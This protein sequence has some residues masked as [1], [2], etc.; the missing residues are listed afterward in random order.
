MMMESNIDSLYQRDK[1]PNIHMYCFIHLDISD[2]L[3][4]A[5]IKSISFED[6][7]VLRSNLSIF[8]DKNNTDLLIDMFIKEGYDKDTESKYVLFAVSNNRYIEYCTWVKDNY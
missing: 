1:Q 3:H 2:S 7:D 6:L 5:S 4:K 8:F